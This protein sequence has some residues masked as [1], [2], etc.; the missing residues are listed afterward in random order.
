[1][2]ME[3]TASFVAGVD[4]VVTVDTMIAHLAGAMGKP[5]WLL[6][7]AE[8][9]WRWS[10]G[11]ASSPWYPSMRLYSQSQPGDWGDVMSR[12]ERDLTTRMERR[13]ASEPANDLFA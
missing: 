5:T 11:E 12:V 8:P 2:D 13:R 4:L 9:D 10:P 7:K 6:L 3:T 1:F